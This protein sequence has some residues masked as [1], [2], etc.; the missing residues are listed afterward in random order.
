MKRIDKVKL[1]QVYEMLSLLDN[2]SAK[3]ILKAICQNPGSSQTQLMFQIRHHQ[4]EISTL[5]SKMVGFGLITET[6]IGKNVYYKP[7]RK[8][9][10]RI[11]AATR[12]FA[13]Y[14]D[15][16]ADRLLREF[17]RDIAELETRLSIAE[18]CN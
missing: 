12:E 9:I 15:K 13:D 17:Q 4:S 10:K 8:E 14:S 11:N 16:V 5:I 2:N 1:K 18:V 3:E 6:K 7:V